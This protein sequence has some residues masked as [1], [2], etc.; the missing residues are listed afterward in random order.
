MREAIA[1]DFKNFDLQYGPQQVCI[2]SGP[3]DALFKVCMTLLSPLSKRNR[4][5]CFAPV[6]EAFVNVPLM[7]TGQPSYVL[8]TDN[9]FQPN[10]EEFRNFMKSHHEEVRN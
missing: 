9:N 3:K 5:V 8:Q 1:T 7:I 4:V 2:C 6:Y 10:I